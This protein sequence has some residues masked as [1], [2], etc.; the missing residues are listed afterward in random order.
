VEI[1]IWIVMDALLELFSKVK[2]SNGKKILSIY[3]VAGFPKLDST[4]EILKLLEEE[5]VDLVELGFPYSD[6]VADGPAIQAAHTQALANGMSLKLLLEQL[7]E[8]RSVV[9]IPILLMG[10]LNPVI[11]YGAENFLK[12]CKRVGI[13]GC[14]LPD[15]PLREFSLEFEKQFMEY[16]ISYIP[17]ITPTTSESRIQEIRSLRTPFIYAVSSPGVTG[18]SLSEREEPRGA[19]SGRVWNLFG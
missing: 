4:I 17:L 15:L 8:L 16:G 19:G 3:M 5:G 9:K 12:D 6:P 1:R 14:I 13:N 10:Y 11:Q 7:S 18:G 2:R